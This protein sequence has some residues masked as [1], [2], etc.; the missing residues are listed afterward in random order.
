EGGILI[1]SDPEL[2]ERAR[3]ISNQGRRTGGAWYEHPSLGTNA[4]LTGFQAVLLL[5]QLD[6]LPEQLARR[7]ER[8]AFLRDK[9]KDIEGLGPTPDTLDERV[10]THGYHLFSM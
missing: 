9:L 2:A 7:M 6:R 10:T 5:N 1:T 3:A 4:R 8:A